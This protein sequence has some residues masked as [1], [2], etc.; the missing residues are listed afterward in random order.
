MLD[1][2]SRGGNSS[3]VLLLLLVVLVVL[4]LCDLGSSMAL[5]YIFYMPCLRSSLV[6]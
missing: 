6:L 5:L 2:D 1:R 3:V 4:L